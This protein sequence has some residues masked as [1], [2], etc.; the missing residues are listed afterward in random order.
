MSSNVVADS[1]DENSFPHKFLLSNTQISR[2]RKDFANN[3]SP[4][5]KISKTA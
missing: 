1:S 5:I 2:L 3:S 4:N